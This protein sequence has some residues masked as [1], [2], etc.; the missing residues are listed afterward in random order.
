MRILTI[1]SGILMV[2]T[3]AF[4]LMNPGQTFLSLAFVV[5]LIMVLNGLIHALAYFIGRGLHNRG[6]NN[7]WILTD[8]LLTLLLGILILCNQLVA[9]AAIPL[10]FGMWMLVAGILRIEAST[11]IDKERKRSNFRTTM[12]TGILTVLVGLFG[13]IN[14]L[15]Q[16]MTTAVL[17]GI[18]L[19]MQGV[20][21][22][23]L[24]IHMPHEKKSY[25]K[26]Y[27][28]K[29]EPVRITDEDETPEKVMERLKMKE[30]EEKGIDP[31]VAGVQNDEKV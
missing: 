24:G 16:W 18:F 20:N 6:D 10:V 12:I 13:F 26:I 28:R 4:C 8:A 7:G 31:S 27:K 29:R 1:I 30:A 5:G 15:V 3:G 25:V 17:L 11:H 14:P 2:L 21:V 19:V 23:E 9:D 22:I